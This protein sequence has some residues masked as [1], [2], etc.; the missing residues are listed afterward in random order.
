MAD[1]AIRDYGNSKGGLECSDDL[2]IGSALSSPPS[3]DGARMEGNP[4]GARSLQGR[5]KIECFG[6]GL[7]KPELCRDGDG[8]GVR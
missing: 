5:G 4:G 7:T 1:I 3:G 8:K 6:G 2:E